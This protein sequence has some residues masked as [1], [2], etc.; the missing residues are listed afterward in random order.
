MDNAVIDKPIFQSIKEAVKVTGL[1]EYYLR[2]NLK[3]GKIP[4][5]RNGNKIYINMP[6]LLAELEKQTSNS[7]ISL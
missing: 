5:I 2:Q 3:A 1:S 7:P 4:H 6:R